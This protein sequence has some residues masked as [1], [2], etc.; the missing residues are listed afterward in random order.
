MYYIA[1]IKKYYNTCLYGDCHN[2]LGNQ[3]NINIICDL[4]ALIISIII[5]VFYNIKKR[6]ELENKIQN[7]TYE[8]NCSNKYK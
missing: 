1:F 2:E 7:D 3:F 5:Q 6:N 8:Q 4:I